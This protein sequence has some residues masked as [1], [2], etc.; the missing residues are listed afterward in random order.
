MPR[1]IGLFCL[2]LTRFEFS[3]VQPKFSAIRC[4]LSFLLLLSFF[5]TK[6]AGQISLPAANHI[7]TLAGN[8]YWGYTGDGQLAIDAQL[9]KPGAVAIDS[10]GNLIIADTLN[11]VIREV[12]ASTGKITT[13][14]GNGTAGYSGDGQLATSAELNAPWGVALDRGGNIYIA[15]TN[16]SLIRRVDANSHTISTVVGLGTPSPAYT[17]DGGPA[18]NAALNSPTSIVFDSAGNY[19]IADTNNNVVRKVSVATGYISTVAGNGTAGYSGDNGQAQSAE[20]NGPVGLA[21]DQAGDLFIADAY[22]NMI[23]EVS[24]LTGT[25]SKV[26]GNGTAGYAGDGG[27][28]TSAEL[29]FPLGVA[30][31][32]AGNLVISDSSNNVV[33]KV[34]ASSPKTISTIAGNGTAG[35]SGDGG[36][37]ASATLSMP[38]GLA[39]DQAGNIYVADFQN[40]AVRAIGLSMAATTTATPTITWNSPA[41]IV[42]LTG[43]SVGQL[44]ATAS[45]AGTFT[46]SPAAGSI[47]SAGLQSLTVLF[48]PS[49]T[50]HYNDALWTVP[51][52]VA[53]A[54]PVI[55]WP[56][57]SPIVY[58]TALSS[59]QL[60]ATTSVAGTFV[61][62][63]ASGT[64]LGV[65]DQ[66]LAATF[67]PTD[68]IDYSTVVATTG[69]TVTTTPGAN[70]ITTV[71]GDGYWGYFG[72]GDQATD[73][74]LASQNGVAVDSFH[75]IYIADT[76]NNVVREVNS[77][78]GVITTIAGNGTQGYS[79][80]GNAAKSAELNAPVE[81]TLDSAGNLYIADTG[82][83]VIRKVTVSTGVIT[84]I[85]GNHT[86]GYS[87]DGG[88][89]TSAELNG[90]M[91]MAFDAS[92][93][94]YIADRFN[95][96]IRKVTGTTI[97]TFAGTGTAGYSGDNGPAASAKL[98]TPTS[99]AFD[100]TGN[101][102]IYD[103]ANNR[104]RK[105][106]TSGTISTVAGNGT[107]GYL[108]DGN[109]ATGAELNLD[110]GLAVDALGNIYISDSNNHVVRMVAASTGK[111]ATVAGNHT[112]GYSG[113]GGLATSAELHQPEDVA[114]D[115]LGNLYIADF[116]NDVVREVG[117]S[118][119][120]A[121][122]VTVSPTSA[123]L[124][125]GQHQSFSATVINSSNQNVNWT[126]S[127]TGSDP[128][129]M[130]GNVY[131]A[132]ATVN[133][134]QTVKV[135][136]TSQADL[137]QSASATVTLMPTISVGVSPNPVNLFA[138]GQQTFTATVTNTTNTAVNWSVSPSDAGTIDS[139]GK[140]TAKSNVTANETATIKATSQAD[141]TKSGTAIVNLLTPCVSNDYSYA[142]SIVIDHTKIP[143][144]DQA[145]FPFLFSATDPAFKSTSNGGH[146][147]SATGNDI[148]FTADQAGQS[149]LDFQLEQYDPASQTIVAWIRIP[150]LSHTQDTT[151]YLFYGNSGV[152]GP[153]Q[154]P[155]GV[156]DANYQGVWHLPN[157]TTLSTNDSTS[158]AHN[159]VG[160]NVTAAS[161]K[162]DGAASFNGTGYINIGNLGSFPASGTIE[163][164]MR[165][166]SLSNYPNAFSTY[167]NG[168]NNAIRFEEDSSGDFSV[169]VGNGSFNGYSYMTASMLPGTWYDVSLTWNSTTSSVTGY[170]NGSQ[171]FNTNSN[172]Y[173]PTAI[174]D[175]TIGG[176]FN[177]ARDWNGLLD[178]VRLSNTSRSAN[179]IAAEYNNEN[180]PSTFSSLGNEEPVLVNPGS[181]SLYASQQTQFLAAAVGPDACNSAVSW[182]MPPGALGNLTGNGLYT[183]PPSISLPQTI[184]ITATNLL[185]TSKTGTAKVTILPPPLNP[186][187]T[188]TE[189]VPPPYVQGAT[190][191]F[192][193]AL[194][195]S[196]GTPISGVSV[197]FNVTGAN[198]ST[199]SATT[200][201][202]G[203]ASFTYTGINSGVDSIQASANGDGVGLSSNTLSV[204][205][206]TPVQNIS[207]T[208]ILG[209]FFLSDNS[210]AFDIQPNA[211]PAFTQTFPNLNF[212][213]NDGPRPF[214]DAITDINGNVI[215]TIVAQGNGY[216]A[217][218]ADNINGCGS[219]LAGS[220]WAFQAVF[221][222]SFMVKQS[223]PLVLNFSAD[224]GFFIGIGNGATRVSGASY[225]L[226]VSTPFLK[227]PVLGGYNTGAQWDQQQVVV[228]FPAPGTYPFEVDYAECCG[229]GLAL[230]MS[231][232]TG[233]T[234]PPVPP[235]ASLALSPGT[236][237]PQP[238]G[239][240]IAFTVQATGPSGAPV[241]NLPVALR[242]SGA[243][244]PGFTAITDSNGKATF[245][246]SDLYSDGILVDSI[247]NIS[248]LVTYSNVVQV[249]AV[250]APT[251]GGST[252]G[253]CG[254]LSVSA[255]GADAI[256]LPNTLS[257]S[258]SATDSA[259][260][261]GN[262]ISYHW[263][264]TGPGTVTFGNSQ[265][266]STSASFT[267]PGS[268]QLQLTANDLNC[269]QPAKAATTLLVAVN[270]EPGTNQGWIGSPAYGAQ[271]SG[272]VPITMTPGVTLTAGTLTVYP[273][274]NPGN[275][276]VNQ[277]VTGTTLANWDT[278]EVPNGSYWITLQG[279]DS[280]G[281]SQYNLALVTVAG[282]NKPGRVTTTVT[283]LVVPAMG[284]PIKIQRTYDTLNAGTIGDFGYGWNLGTNIN[285][286]VDPK[287]DV[288]FTLGGIGHTFYFTPQ[289]LGWF[290]PYYVPAFTA[291]AGFHGTL[292]VAGGGCSST[293]FDFLI[294][295]GNLWDCVGGGMYTA[296]GY[297]YT[298]PAG[299]AYTITAAGS[300]QSIVDKNGNKLTVT[301]GGIASTPSGSSAPTLTV[302]FARDPSNHN[303]INSITDTAGN[304]YG[305]A[306]DTS[307]N[308]RSVTYPSISNQE[309]YTYDSNHRYLSGTD[310]NGNPLPSTAYY[311]SSTDSGN[312]ALD[313]RLLRVTDAL[314]ETTSYTYNLAVAACP[315]TPNNNLV[316]NSTMITYPLDGSGH[317]GT[318]TLNYN[319]AGDVVSST[320]P[321]GFTTTNAYDANRNLASVTDPLGYITCYT[322]DTNGNRLS[323]TVP[324]TGPTCSSVKSTTAYN[325]YSEPTQTTDEDNNTR[326][327][328]YD[329]NYNPVSVTDSIGTLASFHF[330]TAGTMQAG[331]VGYDITANPSRAS[332]FAYDNNGNLS[333]RTDALGR[334][335]SY[336]YN[337]LGQKTSMI[338]PLPNSS[339][340]QAAATTSYTYDDFGNLTETDAPEGRS[341]KSQYDPMGNK[342]QDSQLVNG[343]WIATNYSFDAL[344]RLWK[345]TYA[346]GTPDTAT[347]TKNQLDFRGNVI[348][349]TDQSGNVTYNVYDPGGR[350]TSTTRAYGT[351]NATTTSYTYDN[352]GRKIKQTDN[353]GHMISYAYD[354]AG[355]LIGVAT[356][357]NS[358][359]C[360]TV[361]ANTVCYTYDAARNRM[362][363]TDGNNH[364]TG[365]AYDAR[366]RLTTTTYPDQTT[367]TNAYDGPGNL[368]SVTDQNDHVVEYTYD[369]ANQLTQVTQTSSP[370]SDNTTIVGYDAD[371]NPVAI[372][373]ANTHLTSS[374]FDLLGELKGKTLPDGSLTESRGYDTAGNLK[375]LTH[376]NGV[377]TTYA[378]DNLNRLTSRATP[379]ESTVSFTYTATGKRHTMIDGNCTA[380]DP[381][382]TTTYSYDSMD[383]LTSKATPEGTLTY[384]YDGAGHLASMQSSNTNGANVSYTYDTLNRLSTVVDA[385]LGTSTYT[386]DDANNVATVTY[387][388]GVKATFGYD[389]LNRVTSLSNTSQS[390]P[391]NYE[392]DNAGKK[393]KVTEPGG[394]VAQW[395][396]DNINRLT[397]EGISGGLSGKDGPVAYGLDPVGNR[398]SVSSGISGF[399]P[400]AGTFDKDDRLESE[401]YDQNGNVTATGGKSYMYDTENHLVAMGST[402]TLVY[403]GDGDRVAK[404]IGT[405]TTTYLIDDLNPTGYPQVVDELTNGAVSRTY[406]YGLQRISQWQFVQ[407]S[408]SWVPS[409]YVYDGGGNVR[410]L[411]DVNGNVT[412]TYEYD[413]Y[414]NHW[415]ASG[416]TPN[417]MLYQGEEW[418]PDL[419][420]YYLRARYMNPLTGRFMSRDPEDGTP[421]DP[422][423]L[424]KYV[425][426]GGDPINL[427]DPTG[428][429]QSGR[430]T[431]GG[432]AGDYVGLAILATGVALGIGHNPGAVM[433]TGQEL[434]CGLDLL[435]SAELAT[436][437]WGIDKGQGYDAWIERTDQCHVV[438]K[439]RKKKKCLLGGAIGAVVIGEFQPRVVAT[440]TAM[441]AGSYEAPAGAPRYLW[442]RNN[443]L[444][445]NAVM[446]Q[447]CKIFDIGALPGRAN[448][449]WPTSPYYAMELQQIRLR[450]YPT[451]PIVGV[452]PWPTNP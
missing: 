298:D 352:D 339:T 372:T 28:P 190:Q 68:S 70:I 429:A 234:P 56:S 367:V 173:W 267:N 246:L 32:S 425:Y 422:S 41:P 300:L 99:L 222:G 20:L 102:Y 85:A 186:T 248:G 391:Y 107:A 33:R 90:P 178:E 253:T 158:N 360:P 397:G 167:D 239:A 221:T 124:Y 450:D 307:G 373:D 371:G 235:V 301:S 358:V 174:Q 21:I 314:N 51:L 89:A 404:T 147:T 295:D 436:V 317:Q 400:V 22:N 251:T 408:N 285:M 375:T 325:P 348:K 266:A 236:V 252:P 189:A 8:G 288:T 30:V 14:A 407:S 179:W 86:A 154:N 45:V 370:S 96:R 127:S 255:S 52:T 156:W 128:G 327:F 389:P 326:Y 126:L 334:M 350:L 69:I 50:V 335:T 423:T 241:Q 149:K 192:S 146:I 260:P 383:R 117:S 46:Y 25:I 418:D 336:T 77:S 287:G 393:T 385:R 115:S 57:P 322:Y 245:N 208:A 75:N 67:A 108:G 207:T 19:Y 203:N 424:H 11:N 37:A 319:C 331:A 417:N 216:Q 308:L 396:Y 7:A 342:T 349:E 238:L 305:Y 272:I 142:R 6:A 12:S 291:E 406:T 31:D 63:P 426:A 290:L 10:A 105:V 227:Y 112:A 289:V 201:S 225:N 446:D 237:S 444:W 132:P 64:V 394:R 401:S 5:S 329:V 58:G 357:S 374:S 340:S 435:G 4:Y 116:K 171:V 185:D 303:R 40:C 168:Y 157:G 452:G 196:D 217:G 445:I 403:D 47:L 240:S 427:S 210:G 366:K 204:T 433:A 17:G 81:V 122:S 54:V 333:S 278:T 261:S 410:Q 15:D 257:L 172:T 384:T 392:E 138:N 304:V 286:S 60:D 347:D 169:A 162:I 38:V 292:A 354:P 35:Y 230:A 141:T 363:M 164:W 405:T 271:V 166:S 316:T 312:S 378:Y 18:V 390:G 324:Q 388:N 320:D 399:S 297:V 395:T 313:G 91:G 27:S 419:G 176:G 1:A 413:S 310:F 440:A 402:V 398:T 136:A 55:I 306:Y 442:M 249:P 293:G 256:V 209:Q 76:A 382:C 82:N 351:G 268:Y 24:G 94:L 431:A 451:T 441:G 280:N 381:S 104:I 364:T 214:T 36:L 448:F 80:D 277:S 328:N 243:I 359:S 223:G 215:G 416:T 275:L 434:L 414:G 439:K 282:N 131:T 106:T 3:N 337:S 83:N 42:Y 193:A 387:P 53:Q 48:T 233:S 356:G 110:A 125:A 188:L 184:V 379:G 377:Q 346:V 259:P 345:T 309:R 197:T 140:F 165:A 87:G 428:R 109:A 59:T 212:D 152:N 211:T 205:W 365:Y 264:A 2:T 338:Q 23:R 34:S 432:D 79:G 321:N 229:Y 411:T 187:L 113:D 143:N 228:N 224:D 26:A 438:E 29:N 16:N 265:Q 412:D 296:P 49:D 153:Q 61:Y 155:T 206:F 330:N 114:V 183:A 62:I 97:S 159:G 120:A 355:D 344:N 191:Q 43:L 100:S 443:E 199:T 380:S 95:Q 213:A 145:N 144:T 244:D 415:T 283:D 420:F 39:L 73:A 430:A 270:A 263:S 447:E 369:A 175:L 194:K 323:T 231:Q 200:D 254:T 170:L 226:P 177:E 101:L 92:G 98:N 111:I 150:N 88:A 343:N 386:Y 134:Q 421:T 195:Y 202:F 123:T 332:Q 274:N 180:S 151:I 135:T 284:L 137:G 376:F 302:S 220:L 93:N 84:T 219:N 232:G 318:A 273:T 65:G 121:I 182:S 119:N 181:V 198:P 148:I 299:T 361:S 279:T 258:G 250:L 71:A 78:T 44:N 160:T 13:V 161:G 242:I 315:A 269:V 449:P 66:S 9:A 72:D 368:I 103:T 341:T 247:A 437:Q 118:T 311:D 133:S 218:C 353:L 130:S 163:F 74:E 276:L 409:F 362:S 129:T 281:N 262:T 139:S 294:P